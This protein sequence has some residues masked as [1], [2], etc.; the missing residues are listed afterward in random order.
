MIC[1]FCEIPWERSAALLGF[2]THSLRY[3]PVI[4][5]DHVEKGLQ[6]VDVTGS[7]DAQRKNNN[8]RWQR[9]NT[10]CKLLYHTDASANKGP[11]SLDLSIFV[12]NHTKAF[13]SQTALKIAI[14]L[15]QIH[16]SSVILI[17]G[18][19]HI[20]KEKINN[21]QSVFMQPYIPDIEPNLMFIYLE[22]SFLFN[23]KCEG[24]HWI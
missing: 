14:T 13:R 22:F 15:I 7:I 3:G 6:R 17:E 16:K 1:C 9:M 8:E 23:H 11:V 5:Q 12:Q 20:Y 21:L 24:K 4:L 19:T 18:K 2:H 10:R